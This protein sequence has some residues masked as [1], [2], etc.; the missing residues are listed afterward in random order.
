MTAAKIERLIEESVRPL[1]ECE[2]F[3]VKVSYAAQQDDGCNWVLASYSGVDNHVGPLLHHLATLRKILSPVISR[4]HLV[5]LFVS[6]L[7]FGHVRTI[8]GFVKRR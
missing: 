4:P 5:R 3:T 7:A 6:E 2:A 8:A 1:P